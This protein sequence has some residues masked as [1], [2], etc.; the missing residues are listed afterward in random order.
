MVVIL[1]VSEAFQF[2]TLEF[3]FVCVQALDVESIH[4]G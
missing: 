3:E 4:S 2:H 1:M